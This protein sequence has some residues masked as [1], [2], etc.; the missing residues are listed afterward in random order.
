MKKGCFDI[1]D[2]S[3]FFFFIIMGTGCVKSFRVPGLEILVIHFH[4]PVALWP[5]FEDHGHTQHR[6]FSETCLYN[7]T[8][9]KLWFCVKKKYDVS[10]L[11]SVFQIIIMDSIAN[12]LGDNTGASAK[13]LIMH[14]EI[15]ISD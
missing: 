13:L 14:D 3:C 10:V 9:T 12:S 2:L 6:L 1:I 11:L 4:S 5:H 15:I 8:R 7:I